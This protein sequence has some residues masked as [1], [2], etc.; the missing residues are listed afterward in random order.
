MFDKGTNAA[1]ALGAKSSCQAARS[2]G[3][4]FLKFFE[5]NSQTPL[6]TRESAVY[7]NIR[8][9]LRRPCR[10]SGA[11][12]RAPA[13][14]CPG[15]GSKVPRE[16]GDSSKEGHTWLVRLAR[17]NRSRRRLPRRRPL[18]RRSSPVSSPPEA[19]LAEAGLPPFTRGHPTC[20]SSLSLL[21]F[22]EHPLSALSALR[23]VSPKAANRCGPNSL[24]P[25]SWE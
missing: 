22:S 20:P 24:S 5:I 3:S 9:A 10:S 11:S 8:P 18:P 1:W 2:Q 14:G 7:L 12:A 23:R 16:A 13:S 21:P 4:S 6:T 19:R 17:R 25:C 15:R